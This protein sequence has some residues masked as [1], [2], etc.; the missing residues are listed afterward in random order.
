MLD[1]I[2]VD[3]NTVTSGIKGERQ[4]IGM[5]GYQSVMCVNVGVTG[6]YV[7]LTPYCRCP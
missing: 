1:I 3:V 5:S 6:F 4:D 2:A 7:V